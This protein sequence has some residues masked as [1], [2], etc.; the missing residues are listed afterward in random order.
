MA[1][2]QFVTDVYKYYNQKPYWEV[3][4]PGV[5]VKMTGSKEEEPQAAFYAWIYAHEDD[6]QTLVQPGLTILVCDIGGGTT[7]FTLMHVR[8]GAS[9]HDAED[10]SQ[11]RNAA[12]QLRMSAVTTC[13]APCHHGEH[14]IQRNARH[15]TDEMNQSNEISGGHG[16][17]G[18]SA[19]RSGRMLCM[20]ARSVNAVQ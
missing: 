15:E 11:H 18:I 12:G 1:D 5:Q 10:G 2:K 14:S 19:R 8:D 17:H 9:T 16:V 20:A 7:D 4:A 3:K 6:W 13:G